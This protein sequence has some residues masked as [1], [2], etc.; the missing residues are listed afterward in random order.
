MGFIVKKAPYTGDTVKDTIEKIRSAQN[1]EQKNSSEKR[2]VSND[3][4]S[5][6]LY[7][8][9]PRQRVSHLSKPAGISE[10][11]ETRIAIMKALLLGEMTQGEALKTLRVDVL[12]LKQDIFAKLTGVSRKTLSEVENDKGNYTSD[13]INKV[14]KPFGL[15]VGLV[16]TSRHML[17]AMFKE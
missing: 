9:Q 13:I 14:F 4:S 5:F 16:P 7:K 11:N 8:S 15:Q 17:S 10:R 3:E 12:G 2:T 6:S 1:T